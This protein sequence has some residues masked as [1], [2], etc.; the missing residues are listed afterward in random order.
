[1]ISWQIWGAFLGYII[2]MVISPGPGNTLLAATGG[3]SGL[4][5]S[6]PFW[7][8]FE[9]G[10]LSLCLIYGFGLGH[11]LHTHPAFDQALKWAGTSYLLY[12]AW[13]FFHASTMPNAASNAP[14]SE[15]NFRDGVV[16]VA[17]NPK[18]HSMILVMFS[19]F[20]N[21][22]SPLPSQVVQFTFA[23]MVVSIIC[24]FLWIHAGRVI[25]GRFR[26]KQALRVQGWGFGVCMLA[27]AAYIALS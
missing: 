12:L 25:L 23:F 6:I 13:K 22:A 3:R 2:P 20:L 14:A 17:L 9:V 21:P 8:G 18:I 5:R 1:M 19:Q 10:D 7:A 24:H 16:S 26:S 15:L 11:V 4:W 27:V